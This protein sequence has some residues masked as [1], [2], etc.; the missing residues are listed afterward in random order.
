MYMSANFREW[1][2]GESCGPCCPLGVFNLKPWILVAVY[3]FKNVGKGISENL[4]R[5]F[6]SQGFVWPG[7]GD[8][9]KL[10]R[11]ICRWSSPH[12]HLN[13]N[14]VVCTCIYLRNCF[15]NHFCSQDIVIQQDDEIRLRIVGTR[16]DAKDIVSTDMSCIAV[17]VSMYCSTSRAKQPSVTIRLFNIPAYCSTKYANILSHKAGL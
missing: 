15:L 13:L 11:C 10:P 12:L 1:G 9:S 17:F 8:S 6:N 14:F 4:L 3:C 7:G 16:V 5:F 2:G